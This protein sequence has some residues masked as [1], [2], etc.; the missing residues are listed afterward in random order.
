MKW[1]TNR[2]ITLLKPFCFSIDKQEPGGD[3][4]TTNLIVR[5][6]RDGDPL[7]IYGFSTN[8]YTISQTPDDAEI[9]MIAVTDGQCSS[10]GLNSKDMGTCI[11][12]GSILSVLR[13][14]GFVVVLTHKGYF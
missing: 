12:Y 4:D 1:N 11:L 7:Y 5:H 2:I 8:D 6:D 3:V 14:A 9:E 10:G 13:Q